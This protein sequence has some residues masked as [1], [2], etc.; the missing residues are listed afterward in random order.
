MA[1]V[2]LLPAA[3]DIIGTGG[4][5]FPLTVNITATDIDDDPVSFSDPA[6]IVTD[7]NDETFAFGAPI[8][9]TSGDQIIITWDADATT[10]LTDGGLVYRWAL[11]LTFGGS[12][13]PI[14]G[15]KLQMVPPTQPGASTSSEI[16][17]AVQIG[18]VT[19]NIAVTLAG[20]G[21]QGQPGPQGDRGEQGPQGDVGPTGPTGPPGAIGPDGPQGTKG[22]TGV[23]G[24][25]GNTGLTGGTGPD[26]ATGATGAQG[27]PGVFALP[28]A[29]KYPIL[30][31]VIASVL[32]GHADQKVLMVGDSTYLGIF[33]N[34]GQGPT[35][36]IVKFLT[37]DGIPSLFGLSGAPGTGFT[38]AR[39][40]VGSGWSS[41]GAG[42][43][44]GWGG[45]G[46]GFFGANGAS[47]AL[48]YTPD[49]GTY[50]SFDI[51]YFTSIV[52]FGFKVN[53]N[54]GADTTVNA[55]TGTTTVAKVT[56]SGSATAMPTCNI[57]TPSGGAVIIG[58]EPRLST[59]KHLYFAN[60]GVSGSDTAGWTAAGTSPGY[61]PLDC[62]KAYAPDLTIIGL[63]INDMNTP[64]SQSTYL[65]NMA[66]IIAAAEVSGGVVLATETPQS[67]SMLA[68]ASQDA[69]WANLISY[70]KAQGLPLV[71]VYGAWGGAAA[72]SSLDAA[73]Y[74]AGDHLHPGSS[75]GQPENGRTLASGLLTL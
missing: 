53:F 32:S 10:A 4:S 74:F 15:G 26:G 33:A 6:I 60:V 41:G 12:R 67:T 46:T 40:S 70:A 72:Q 13:S 16:D 57:H 59:S 62:I 5:P 24:D 34:Y 51:Y 14:V 18:D 48:T 22:D 49:V 58:V 52:T 9:N 11:I 31:R 65:A 47:G 56:V 50:D 61:G 69:Y 7:Q 66:Q 8:I 35:P 42:S 23:K 73:G 71:D 20:F 36:Y 75:Y 25:T 64:I 45:N 17:A 38:D 19:A 28:S 43:T 63:G 44:N 68:Q 27:I 21:E 55:D 29:G 2:S 30:H 39:W 37:A 3:F 54:G 1:T